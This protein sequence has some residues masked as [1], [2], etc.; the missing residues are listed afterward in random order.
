MLFH[1]EST[2]NSALIFFNFLL[3]RVKKTAIY[4]CS[5]RHFS[6]MTLYANHMQNG[7]NQGQFSRGKKKLDL[8]SS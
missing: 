7:K 5:I 3:R 4:E 8:D 1:A 2:I 6:K